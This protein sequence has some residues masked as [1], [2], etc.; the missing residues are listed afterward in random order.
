MQ[1]PEPWLCRSVGAEG[2]PTLVLFD[3]EPSKFKLYSGERT[4]KAMAAFL[5]EEIKAFLRRK[6]ANKRKEAR[7]KMGPG[8]S[9]KVSGEASAAKTKGDFS[10]ARARRDKDKG[11]GKAE[12]KKAAK[13]AA[14][15]REAAKSAPQEQ[16]QASG[17]GLEQVL[18]GLKLERLGVRHLEFLCE[19][20]SHWAIKSPLLLLV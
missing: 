18:H 1:L 20:W 12:P 11:A 9:S 4:K 13:P 8:V 17:E 6:H 19:C 7:S 3:G 16:G 2:F 14:P 5:Q 15:K 10:A